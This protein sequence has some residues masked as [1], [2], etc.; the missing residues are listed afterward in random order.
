M[1][2]RSL[3][4]PSSRLAPL[5]FAVAAIVVY[6][7]SFGSQVLLSAPVTARMSVVPFALVQA[8]LI[9]LWIALHVR[10]L[11]DAGRS[12]GLAVGIAIVYALEI[13]LLTIMV[14][15]ILESS[16][17][18]TSGGIGSDATILQ[19]FVILYLLTLLSGDPTLGALQIWLMG[20]VVLMLLPVAIALGFSLWAATRTSVSTTP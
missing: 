13:V 9:W 6:L 7:L 11:H 15:L 18:A 2:L 4:S 8:A 16:G 1:S 20:F 12:A 3:L 14:W 10:R 5:P 19:L 17:A